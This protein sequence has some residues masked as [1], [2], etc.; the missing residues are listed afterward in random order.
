[1][2]KRSLFIAWRGLRWITEAALLAGMTVLFLA[3]VTVLAL[4]YWVLPNADEYRESIVQAFSEAVGARVAVR[5]IRADWDGFR[6]QLVLEDLVVY[7][8]EG[9]PALHLEQTKTVLTWPALMLGEIS[10]YSIELVGPS[11]QVRRDAGGVVH[12][13]GIAVPEGEAAGELR[14]MGWLLAQRRVVVRDARILWVDEKRQARALLLDSVQLRLENR[15]SRHRFGLQATPPGD[16]ASPLDVRGDFESRSP[17]DLRSW[18]GTLYAAVNRVDLEAWNAWIPYPVALSRGSGGVRLWLDASQGAPREVTADLRLSDVRVRVQQDLPELALIALRGRLA[19]RHLENGFHLAT[20]GLSLATRD[21]LALR[22]TDFSLLSTITARDRAGGGEL[23]ANGL[24]LGALVSLSDYLPMEPTIRRRLLDFAPQGSVHDVI[25]KWTGEWP[26]PASYSA[27]GHF[28]NLGLRPQGKIPGFSGVTG[29]LD[30]TEKGGTFSVSSRRATLELPL[31]FRQALELDTVTAQA[32][33]TRRGKEFELR[34]ANVSFANDQLSGSVYG[35]Y[36]GTAGQAGRIDLTGNLIHA[37]ARYAARYVPLVVD[38]EARR[39]LDAAVLAGSSQEV[40]LRVKGD[41][42][43]FPF[44]GSRAGLFE[45]KARVTGGT[46]FYAEGWPKIE[47]ISGTALFR[48][49]RLDV[50]ADEANL[51]G[52]RLSRVRA[53]IP[54]LAGAQQWLEVEGQ[55]DGPTAEFLRLIEASPVDGYIDGLTRGVRA[56]GFGSL[57]LKLRMPLPD[58]EHTRVA[59]SYRFLGNR[60]EWGPDIPVAEEVNGTL[61]FTESTVR[62]Q[63]AKAVMLGGPATVNVNNQQEGGVRI[64]LVGWADAEA[65]ART[66]EYEIA[67]YLHGGTD[68]RATVVLKE[69]QAKSPAEVVV[70]SSLQGLASELPAPLG[71]KAGEALPLRVEWRPAGAGRYASSVSLGRLVT[72]RG[73]SRADN[74]RMLIERGAASFGGMA[75]LPDRDGV[76]VSGTV[77]GLDI[78]GWRG[79]FSGSKGTLG[80]EL[81]A[82]DL[83]VGALDVLGRRFSKLELAASRQGSVWQAR[84]DGPEVKGDLRWDSRGKGMVSGRFSKFTIPDDSPVAPGPAQPPE[85]ET[86]LP[87]LDLSVEEFRVGDKQFGQ[88]E[89]RA[90]QRERNWQIERLRI[91]NPDAEFQATGEWQGWASSPRTQ[92]RLTLDMVNMGKLLGRLGYRDSMKWGNGKLEGDLGWAGNPYA[93]DYPTLEGALKLR[94]FKGQFLQVEPGAGKLLGILSLQALPRRLLLDFRDVVDAGF[95]FDTITASA[96][97]ARGVAITRDFEMVGSSA[98]VTMNG[99]VDLAAE[100]QNLRVRIVPALSEGVSIAGSVIGGPVVGAA[101]LFL[102]KALKDPLGQI[103]AVEYN[104]TGSWGEPMV[105]RVGAPAASAE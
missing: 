14:P 19:W 6:P 82:V 76:W 61:E 55:A 101:T 77:A 12:V 59:G 102:S 41:L 91:K 17:T 47:N 36:H 3:A 16:L 49:E 32:S 37:D 46:L 104:V 30:G 73:I 69:G 23:R 93:L 15:G 100:S 87:S 4:R 10:L 27:K 50:F 86:E 5:A 94:A 70:E 81:S 11:L 2:L 60:L 1:M 67:K 62:A 40:T 56:S 72:A 98:R 95:E 74:G 53:E 90:E 80:A 92:L 29:S 45:V 43:D 85:H 42:N 97:L 33:W 103:A 9:R 52:T 83:Q 58:A 35:T 22:P 105:A 21:G 88:L 65:M 44:P 8:Q 13:A 99:E 68:W 84:L 66:S 96:I 78:D 64:G 26:T 25:V 38:E 54:D 34:L 48:G 18:S 89:L 20:G 28:T 79:V 7:D 31:V 75:V 71:K 39:W 24:D 57:T 63:D 51:M